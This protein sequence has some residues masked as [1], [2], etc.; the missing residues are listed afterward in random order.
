ME[1]RDALAVRYAEK[2]ATDFRS[3]DAAFMSELRAHF[4]DA[5]ISELGL[6]IGQYMALGRMLVISGG[7]KMACEIYVPPD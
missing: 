5:E 4:S 2:M 6:M 1:P 7:H 3:V